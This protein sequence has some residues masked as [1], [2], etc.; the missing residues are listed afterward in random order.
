MHAVTLRWTV[1]LLLAGLTCLAGTGPAAAVDASPFDKI[2][3]RWVGEG[4]LGIRDGATEQVKCRVTY[5]RAGN[6][7][8]L[9]QTIRCA[10]GSGSIEVRSSVTHTSGALSGSWTEL[11]RNMS[12]DVTG[13]VTPKGF[14]VQIKGESLNANMDIVVL[15]AKQVIEIQFM[16]SSLIGLTL[17]LDKG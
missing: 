9:Q 13:I 2:M 7:D 10:S 5:M 17:I 8:E 3:G 11:S 4:R 1:A 15:G 16:N 14:R 6:A 12:G